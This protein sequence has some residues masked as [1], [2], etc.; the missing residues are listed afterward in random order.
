MA[1]FYLDP[2]GGND[3]NDGTTFAN[4]WKTLTS[5]A[6]AA[7]IAPGDTIRI[8]ASPDPYS[9]ASA[10]WTD[11]SGTVTWA[12]AKNL[13]IDDCETNWTAAA[14]VTCVLDTVRHKQGS[15]GQRVTPAT[16]FTTGKLAYRTLPSTLD[17][18]TYEQVSLWFR[19]GALTSAGQI[20]LKLCS[21]T[22]G[23][24]P[25]NTLS[26][27]AGTNSSW[28]TAILDNA[29]AL[30]SSIAS[31]ALYAT[32]DPGTTAMY[33]D[34]IVACKAASSSDCVTH[35]HVI[36]KNTVGEPE[37]YSILSIAA[38]SVVIGGGNIV[39]VGNTNNSP[40]PYRGT[41]ESVATYLLLGMP[42]WSSS[43][44]V[45]QDSGDSGSLITFSGGWNRTD[46]STQT[47]VSYFNGS[48]F[49]ANALSHLAKSFLK[50]EKVGGLNLTDGV[51]LD[52][53]GLNLDVQVE[54][55]VGCANG[56]LPPLGIPGRFL[57]L[58]VGYV[59]GMTGGISTDGQ[60][61][62][63]SEYRITRIHGTCGS[64]SSVA[65]SAFPNARYFIDRIDNNSGYGLGT[66][67][68]GQMQSAEIVGCTFSNNVSGDVLANGNGILKTYGCIG[69]PVLSSGSRSSRV[70]ATRDQ[71]VS[72]AHKIYAR[73]FTV[74]TATDRVHTGT[75]KSWKVSPFDTNEC[76]SDTP[77]QF[78]LAEIA[79][80]ASSLVTIK[81][82]VN[83]D[84]TGISAG[85]RILAD[86][87]PGVGTSDIETLMTA[88]V[89]TWE[90]ITLT[91]TPTV[92][93]VVE[94]LGVAWGGTTNN[95]WFGGPIT[96]TQA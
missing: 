37:W 25:V 59:Q 23:D 53:G 82:W 1:T 20:Q 92:A 16:A 5:G 93:G 57:K 63:T 67:S 80:N 81:C 50:I 94:V 34:N 44:N 86:A 27:P 95:A 8:I 15:N 30:G 71:G 2:V 64:T 89:D 60:Y 35:E 19:Y 17:L 66:S 4:R 58:T 13:V 33:V 52:N 54:Q 88:A 42:A 70:L 79:V 29:A 9:P 7:R 32:A 91:F 38:D 46:M 11:N 85:I 45:I 26:L 18:S 43:Q 56:P 36:G 61:V 55:A 76:T 6:T 84:N 14:N 12:A 47:G 28:R 72:T 96:V 49:Q 51:I 65:L 41:T 75:S 31:I 83:R 10:T 87:L 78:Q 69:T 24:T 48:H 74:A 21:D 40:L 77:A 3:A 90:E 39:E 68:I 22:T 62:G 73:Y